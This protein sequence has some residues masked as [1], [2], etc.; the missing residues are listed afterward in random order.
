MEVQTS[1]LDNTD[2]DLV[3]VDQSQS[4][5]NQ[6]TDESQTSSA[7][8]RKA[9]GSFNL[10]KSNMTQSNN[11]NQ[12]EPNSAEFNGSGDR[13]TMSHRT[14]SLIDSN[15]GQIGVG[16]SVSIKLNDASVDQ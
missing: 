13:N 2:T 14:P 11:Q 4:A 12:L 8:F 15:N 6:P 16:Q 10:G 5:P 1:Q 7:M 9:M 3:V